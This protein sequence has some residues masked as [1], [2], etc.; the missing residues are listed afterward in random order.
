MQEIYYFQYLVS[1]GAGLTWIVTA[2]ALSSSLEA[3]FLCSRSKTN[4]VFVEDR[5]SA[6]KIYVCNNISNQPI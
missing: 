3:F 1:T 6:E 4:F 2:A 5:T